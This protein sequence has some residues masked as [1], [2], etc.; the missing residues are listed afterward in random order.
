MAAFSV[1]RA[2]APTFVGPGSL[3]SPAALFSLQPRQSRLRKN[4]KQLLNQPDKQQNVLTHPNLLNLLN[5][6]NRLLD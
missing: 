3:S 4:K 5:Q 2:S 1:E 6:P